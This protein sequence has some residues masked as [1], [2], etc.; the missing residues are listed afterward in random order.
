MVCTCFLADTV[1]AYLTYIGITDG[2]LLQD[3]AEYK[4]D[5][6]SSCPC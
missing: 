1:T 4:P 5:A 6:N 3:A 2:V